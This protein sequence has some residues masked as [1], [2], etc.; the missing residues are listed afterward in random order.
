VVSTTHETPPLDRPGGE[1][2]LGDFSG[3]PFGSALIPEER[4]DRVAIES[5]TDLLIWKL[6]YQANLAK[7]TN[8]SG[9]VQPS[10]K[11]GVCLH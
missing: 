2:G 8:C 11:C 1:K 4:A 7:D 9:M 10:P 3:S 6:R 5:H